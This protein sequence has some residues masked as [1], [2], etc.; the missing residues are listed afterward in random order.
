ML[1][2]SMKANNIVP[3]SVLVFLQIIAI[4]VVNT[5]AFDISLWGIVKDTGG[6]MVAIGAVAGVL[7]LLIPADYKSMLV[8]WRWRNTLPGHRFIQLAE[9]D[10]RIDAK[11]FKARIPE[12][13]ALKLNQSE[14]NSYWY[15]EFYR[16]VTSQDE[17]A[18]THK[19]YL[20][21]RDATA[22]ALVSFLAL[23]IAKQVFTTLLLEVSYQSLWVFIAAF[24]LFTIAAR[25]AGQRMVTTAVAVSLVA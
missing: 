17:V 19:S 15:K 11:I 24:V 23:L 2:N 14:Q 25:N 6:S 9:K 8:F 18:S 13:D 20:L 10:M 1:G 22:V 4:S 21:Y 7:S 16:P 3:L 5:N 12:Y